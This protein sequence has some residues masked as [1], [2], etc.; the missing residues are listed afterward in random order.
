MV[1]DAYMDGGGSTSGLNML[2]DLIRLHREEWTIMCSS[3][4]VYEHSQKFFLR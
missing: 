3:M 4:H 2:G 1:L